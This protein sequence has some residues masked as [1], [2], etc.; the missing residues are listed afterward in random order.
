MVSS[1][2]LL[3]RICTAACR[4][5][6]IATWAN[7]GHVAAEGFGVRCGRPARSG[8][9]DDADLRV[10]VKREIFSDGDPASL[11]LRH[12]KS[13]RQ[14]P[15]DRDSGRP[16]DD[17]RTNFFSAVIAAQAET[18]VV[19]ST[20]GLPSWTSTPAA[21]QRL[22]R[23]G[24]RLFVE[25]REQAVLRVDEDDLRPGP[26]ELER[27]AAARRGEE[28]DYR[29]GGLDPGRSSS[30]HDD[31]RRSTVVQLRPGIH[32]FEGSEQKVANLSQRR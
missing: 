24:S 30:H 2:S 6:W 4:P 26:V 7:C 17:V 3:R 13:C 27:V 16:D 20:T 10:T 29:A 18:A 21:A 8:V 32:I 1:P 19:T 28:L 9:P 14:G 11:R 25:T 31:G 23:V 5:D 12:R 22:E 15:V